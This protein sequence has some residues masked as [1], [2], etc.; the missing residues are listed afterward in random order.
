[1]IDFGVEHVPRVADGVVGAAGAGRAGAG[2]PAIRQRLAI[3]RP[4]AGLE[5]VEDVNIAIAVDVAVRVV[6]HIADVLAGDGVVDQVE[7]IGIDLALAGEV[8]RP[9]VAAGGMATA[10][11]G[12]VAC[13]SRCILPSSSKAMFLRRAFS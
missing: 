13:N 9:L 11:R 2:D 7:V 6:P 12:Y 8:R 1:M 10:L 4:V 3:E 5:H